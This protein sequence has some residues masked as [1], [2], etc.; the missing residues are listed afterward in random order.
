MDTYIALDLET[1]GYSAESSEIIE[2][3]AW[4]VEKGVVVP[5]EYP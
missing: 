4:K 1:T 2:I 5:H 3:G